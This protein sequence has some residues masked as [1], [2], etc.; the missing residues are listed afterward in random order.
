[1]SVINIMPMYI[2]EE[3]VYASGFVPKLIIKDDDYIKESERYLQPYLCHVPRAILGMGI[4]GRFDDSSGIIFTDICDVMKAMKGLFDIHR[5]LP[6]LYLFNLR[7]KVNTQASRNFVLEEME[8]LK[9]SLEVFSGRS[10]GERELRDAIRVMNERRRVV[11]SFY[12]R[13]RKVCFKA[14]SFYEG[15]KNL[16]LDPG[17]KFEPEEGEG[18]RRVVLCGNLCGG[19]DEGIFELIDELGGWV[20]DDD[21]YIGRRYFGELVREDMDPLHALA[22]KYIEDIP[23]PTKFLMAHDYGDY[24]VGLVRESGARGVI[25]LA[26]K[27]CE[28]FFFDYPFVKRR[29]DREG[30]PSILLELEPPFSREAMRTRLQGFFEIME[31]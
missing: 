27:Y 15:I 11:L 10:V 2:P 18:E 1:M 14:S 29:L 7:G 4:G 19:M 26:P 28:P 20:V 13:R 31:G 6:F 3:I 22:R 23:C 24:I 16:I 25:F 21:L 17:Y 8:R 9:N 12:E 30:I 5:K